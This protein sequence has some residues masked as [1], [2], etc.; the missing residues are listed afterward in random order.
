MRA[1]RHVE[2][3]KLA[4]LAPALG[5]RCLSSGSVS[6]AG[7]TGD[8]AG[9]VSSSENGGKGAATAMSVAADHAAAVLHY[10]TDTQTLANWLDIGIVARKGRAFSADHDV[11]DVNSMEA[12]KFPFLQVSTLDGEDVTLP[13]ALITTIEEGEGETV[14]EGSVTNGVKV[15]CFSFKQ[16]GF[17]LLRSWMEPLWG[18][19]GYGVSAT[20]PTL[21]IC[22]V[23]YSFLSMAKGMFVSAIKD[24][25]PESNH[26][27]TTLCFGG[28]MD[29]SSHLLLPNKFTGYVI[30][31][32]KNNKV[33]WRACGQA[34]D[35]E[36][37]RMF[38]AIEKLRKE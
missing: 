37:Q 28:I 6:H 8:A 5:L 1:L 34:E 27:L 16:Y 4:R 32:D 9:G 15:I 3:L 22:F 23:E 2:S 36:V 26:P 20:V 25:V 17:G 29:F 10:K 13:D 38:K 33:R 35:E 14:G 21:E 11:L 7:G 19:Y 30:V 18:K 24:K 12:M 31:L